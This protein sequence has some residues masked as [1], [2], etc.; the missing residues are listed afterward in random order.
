VRQN[1]TFIR[2]DIVEL[3]LKDQEVTE[4]SPEAEK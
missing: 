2:T 4:D 1:G 3:L